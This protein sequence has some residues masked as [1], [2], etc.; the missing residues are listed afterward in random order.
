MGKP[1][2][3]TMPHDWLDYFP[4]LLA[5]L[6][7][8]ELLPFLPTKYNGIIQALVLFGQSVYDTLKPKQP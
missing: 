6:G 8:S 5:A 2:V 3:K 7:A 1:Q 4:F